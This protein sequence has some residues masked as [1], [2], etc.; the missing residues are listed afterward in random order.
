MA[1]PRDIAAVV[2]FL[3]SEDADFLTGTSIN[4]DGGRSI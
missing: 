2:T 1:E 4:V 3:A